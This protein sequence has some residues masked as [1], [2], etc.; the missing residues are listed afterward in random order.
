VTIPK[1]QSAEIT[2]LDYQI[3]G[4]EAVKVTTDSAGAA[5]SY[6]L[7]SDA[8]SDKTVTFKILGSDITGDI[9]VIVKSTNT[10]T[11]TFK[12]DET[13]KGGICTDSTASSTL[14]VSAGHTLLASEIP[15]I[16]AKPGYT[17]SWETD[18]T[19]VTVNSNLTYTAT[20]T[21][22]SYEVTWA[23]G[24]SGETTAKYTG[25]TTAKHGKD[26]TFTP[27]ISGEIVTD[28]ACTV[29]ESGSEE[30][31]TVTL[32][33][34]AN[35]SYTLP[36]AQITGAITIT[37]TSMTASFEFISYDQ[38]RG[39]ASATQIAVLKFG[40]TTTFDETNRWF[41]SD[42]TPF[43]WSKNYGAYLAIV[44]YTEDAASLSAK[45]EY[46]AYD[47]DG[48]E[49]Y[50]LRYD[51]DIDH[52]G[53]V[54]VHDVNLIRQ[55][56]VTEDNCDSW[57]NFYDFYRLEMDVNRATDGTVDKAVNVVDLVQI[58]QTANGTNTN[59]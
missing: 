41:L 54:T 8:D 22:A 52:D 36:G 4:A 19:G 32:T 56:L 11:I 17:G 20:F 28:V 3:G 47:T 40:A 59:S 26:F 31:K 2:E 18:P 55:V 50:V 12:T 33:K 5:I 10:Y 38:Y 51:G 37:V 49:A 14:V 24:N 46:A 43:Y 1:G 34:N 44:R 27:T 39:L 23:N 42:G 45:L 30:P 16:V 53:S 15:E 21:D 7:R 29:L 25:S 58:W 57:S 48:K 6:N 9:S 35:G 13:D